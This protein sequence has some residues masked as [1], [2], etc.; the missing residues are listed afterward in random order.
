MLFPAFELPFKQHIKQHRKT[1]RYH[2]DICEIKDIGPDPEFKKIYHIAQTHPID[3]I[4]DTSA[5]DQRDAGQEKRV[6]PLSAHDDKSAQSDHNQRSERD[7]DRLPPRHH[8]H[9]NSI[10]WNT[11]NV[12]KIIDN[13]YG[14]QHAQIVNHRIF[15]R[16]IDSHH[17]SDE[18]DIYHT[19]EAPLCSYIHAKGRA[20]SGPS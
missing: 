16:L 12:K 5:D 9:G 18:K 11:V 17:S 7:D 19:Y 10:V 8:S 1:S 20:A 4:P 15:Q 3:D 2:A 6:Q 14:I 13:G